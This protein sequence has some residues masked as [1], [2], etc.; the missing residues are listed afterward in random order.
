MSLRRLVL[1]DAPFIVEL[2]NDPGWIRFI[3]D[4]N[5]HSLDD[6]RR[7]LENGPMKLYAKHGF[8]LWI[9]ERRSDGAPVGMCGLVKRDQLED[10]DLGFAFLP[11]YRGQGYAHEASVGVLDYAWGKL[12]FKRIVAIFTASN[13]ISER[14]LRKLGFVP[15][16]TRELTPGDPVNLYAWS[17]S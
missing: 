12:G 8:G 15:E 5:V 16:G 9:V 11:A 3:G 4:R 10:V 6:A 2:V 17:R 14:L 13:E 1:E 7:Y